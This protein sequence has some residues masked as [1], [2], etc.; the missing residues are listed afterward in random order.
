MARQSDFVAALT[1]TLPQGEREYVHHPTSIRGSTHAYSTS[2][3]RLNTIS[4]VEYTSTT[5]MISVR[6][7]LSTASTKCWP[8]PGT[9]KT[10]STTNEPVM[11]AA[12]AGPR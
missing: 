11:A 5:P 10:L 6:S 2:T 1:P 3:T 8:T 4:I 9:A 7:L 12:H